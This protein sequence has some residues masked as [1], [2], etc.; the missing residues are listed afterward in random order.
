MSA[1]DATDARPSPAFEALM[2]SFAQRSGLPP[3]SDGLGLE[4]QSGAYTARVLPEPGQAQR[5]LIEVQWGSAAQAPASALALLHRVNH[6]ARF[7]HGWWASL[8]MDERLSL[9]TA[10]EL[11][12]TDA[13]ALEAALHEGLQRAAALDR[14]W[15]QALGTDSAAQV[16]QSMPLHTGALRA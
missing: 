6:V 4:L 9:H 16:G 12:D 8:D 13:G 1:P 10:R 15:Q 11:A 7:R 14:L 3:P 5:L 2:R